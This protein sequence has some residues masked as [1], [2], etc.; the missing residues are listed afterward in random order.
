[1]ASTMVNHL[2]SN[3]GRPQKNASRQKAMKIVKK[4]S[5]ALQRR[6]QVQ[7]ICFH[8]SRVLHL[9]NQLL[10][11]QF[12]RTTMIHRLQNLHFNILCP[13]L[14]LFLLSHLCHNLFLIVIHNRF[15]FQ[16][17]AQILFLFQTLQDHL[18]CHLTTHKLKTLSLNVSWN[19]RSSQHH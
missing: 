3:K 5:Q 8:S 16:T 14:S 12:L 2:A 6:L 1:M 4:K 13:H 15:C 18:R 10:H 17:T 19:L 7:M 11:Y 9:A